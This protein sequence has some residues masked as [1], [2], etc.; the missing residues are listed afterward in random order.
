MTPAD[1]KEFL[2][3]VLGFAELRGRQLSAPALELYW[4]AMESWPL[5]TFKAAAAHLVRTCEFMPTPF[6]FE[7]LR[8][9]GE[10]TAAEAWE[11]VLKGEPL[12][13]GSRTHRAAA[14]I[15]GQY[16]VRHADLVH[17]VPHL[18]RHFIEAYDELAE[19]DPVREEL[20]A[21]ARQFNTLTH[22]GEVLELSQAVKQI[23]AP[24]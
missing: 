2:E 18:R 10:P 14:T 17:E 4:R 21:I 19:V 24:K 16:H 8:R 6:H 11:Q 7:Q 23:G 3:I 22:K 5:S 9:A 20:P 13:G 1:R 12:V 15:G